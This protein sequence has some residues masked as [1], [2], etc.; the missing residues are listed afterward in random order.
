[1]PLALALIT[2]VKA[3]DDGDTFACTIFGCGKLV[4]I[5]VAPGSIDRNELSSGVRGELDGLASRNSE[6][7]G[8]LNG[9]DTALASHNASIA[10]HH[11][12][13]T[14]TENKNTE[15]DGR[16]TGV[17]NKNTEQD[18]R[19]TGVE[20]KNT[21]QDGRLTGVENKNTEQ[22]KRLDKND[23]TD[24]K[25]WFAIGGL[26]HENHQQWKAIG[27]LAAWNQQQDMRLNAHE[28]I[29]SQHSATLGA[30][31]RRLDKHEKG[32]AIAMSMPDTWLSDKEKFAIA[33]NIGGFGDETALGFAMI[34]RVNETWS[35]NMGVGTDTSGNEFGWKAGARAG[36]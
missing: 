25:Q 30:H 28:A 31:S 32:L 13:I 11:A 19:L 8:R 34:G 27:G 26:A 6:Q 35:L 18:G 33:G 2:P 15:Q 10:S 23:K 9:I 24:K 16:L 29:L 22:D 17:E 3:D 14:A 12:R 21:E 4:E 36:W 1:L 5:D 7:D 20:N